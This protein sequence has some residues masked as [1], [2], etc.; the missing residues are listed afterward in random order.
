MH[1]DLQS[2]ASR[3]GECT[4]QPRPLD[5]RTLRNPLN[6]M[7]PLSYLL[8]W[9]NVKTGAYSHIH[10]QKRSFSCGILSSHASRFFESLAHIRDESATQMAS[11][12]VQPF[13]HNSLVHQTHIYPRYTCDICNKEPRHKACTH[14]ATIES[15]KLVI[16]NGNMHYV[17]HANHAICVNAA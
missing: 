5:R 2:T 12:S 10:T 15:H 6:G 4:R 14:H 3:V 9:R 1:W 13:L 16:D 17:Q 7:S 11:R 8:A